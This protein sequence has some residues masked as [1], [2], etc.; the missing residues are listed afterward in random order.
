MKTCEKYEFYS[1]GRE[2]RDQVLIFTSGVGYATAARHL[3]L[4]GLAAG[5]TVVRGDEPAEKLVTDSMG[6]FFRA[7]VNHWE[8]LPPSRYS[9]ACRDFVQSGEH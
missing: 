8:T 2:P 6:N 1:L 5:K 4:C 7:E 3:H 9:V